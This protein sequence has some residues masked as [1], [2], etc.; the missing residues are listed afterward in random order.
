MTPLVPSC[1]T[2]EHPFS[3]AWLRYS[4]MSCERIHKQLVSENVR[5]DG[6]THLFPTCQ[7]RMHK[8]LVEHRTAFG[9]RRE[10]PQHQQHLDFIVKGEPS[11][12]DIGECFDACEQ[13]KNYP[14]HHPFHLKRKSIDCELL[15]HAPQSTATYVF[16]NIFC[17]N[18]FV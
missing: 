1:S 9:G 2:A 8:L 15:H 16:F 7:H 11:Q 5:R 6:A 12:E 4:S 10:Q 18:G 3:L 17:S 13:R 14:V